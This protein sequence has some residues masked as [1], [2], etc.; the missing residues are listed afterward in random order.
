MEEDTEILDWGNEDDEQ[1][2]ESYG[3]QGTT[4]PGYRDAED[5]E[6][7]VSLGG[8]ED[9]MQQFY[10]YQTKE[11]E[12]AKGQPL[13]PKSATLPLPPLPKREVQRELSGSAQKPAPAPSQPQAS[14]SPQLKRSLSAAKLTH[15][16]PPKPVVALPPFVP[17]TP[18]QITTLAGP[19][20]NRDRRANGHTKPSSSNDGRDSRDVLPSNW[21]VRY[22][23][24]GGG[25]EVYYYNVKTHES[26]WS[27]PVS[28]RSSPSKDREHGPMRGSE[29]RSP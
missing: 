5:A 26:T 10:S 21:E 7:A 2:Q 11:E 1:H 17:T 3:G 25:R 8:D 13:T 27:R 19:M 6:D 24:A 29:G 23:R 9:D 22:P 12:Q 14:G 18:A 4:P 28:G 16:L 20:V 15:A